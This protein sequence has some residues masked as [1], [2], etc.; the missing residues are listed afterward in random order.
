MCD[1]KT[2]RID[3]FE[4][5]GLFTEPIEKKNDFLLRD[6]LAIARRKHFGMCLLCG[7]EVLFTLH[8][9]NLRETV[10][11]PR[12][13]SFN[14]QRQLIAALSYEAIGTVVA[15]PQLVKKVR[16]GTRILLLESVTNLAAVFEYYA[17]NRVQLDLAEYVDAHL[18]SGDR[19][20]EHGVLHLDIEDTHYGDGEFDYIL[21]ADVFEHVANAP[22]AEKE[23]LRILKKR[24]AAVYTAP[25]HSQAQHDD[26]RATLEDGQVVHHAEAIYHG[27]PSPG[28]EDGSGCLVYRIF[29]FPD[30]RARHAE[31]G[32]D[33]DEYYLYS[34]HYGILGN[35]GFVHVARKR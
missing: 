12:C 14:R 3:H 9:A 35:N 15:L 31:M 13:G 4:R 8:S 27:D 20:Q 32:A 34:G 18:S 6:N 22:R 19:T 10:K 16:K 2:L 23:Q 7:E 11:C 26:V 29:S 25:F 28:N 17:G 33:F 30:M 1:M 24:G 21:H 5:A